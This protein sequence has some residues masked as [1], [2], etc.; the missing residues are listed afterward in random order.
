VR[1][2]GAGLSIGVGRV[3]AIVS[4]YVAGVLLESGWPASST[5]VLFALPLFAAGAATLYLERMRSSG[6]VL[7]P[8]EQR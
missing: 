3:G 1:N 4:P 2:T 8:E 6:P 5:Y 7:R